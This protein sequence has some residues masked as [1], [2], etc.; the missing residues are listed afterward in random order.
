[1]C[2][3]SKGR[4]TTTRL[5]TMQMFAPEKTPRPRGLEA[6]LQPFFSC[7]QFLAGKSETC[8]IFKH[9]NRSD[10]TDYCNIRF[11]VGIVPLVTMSNLRFRFL[12][13]IFTVL[14]LAKSVQH[15]LDPD[16]PVGT[17]SLY[18]GFQAPKR[19]PFM[20]RF[21]LQPTGVP[22]TVWYSWSNSCAPGT[23]G[24]CKCAST[25]AVR[26]WSGWDFKQEPLTAPRSTAE[27]CQWFSFVYSLPS[28][29]EDLTRTSHF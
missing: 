19:I 23:A 5:C 3:A 22:G 8:V 24:R 18:S 26:C 13:G 14:Q 20:Q 17:I 16:T 6:H 21:K 11:I 10:W 28:V 12:V 15:M 25:R 9:S 29:L 2:D 27:P 4:R 1:V 7:L